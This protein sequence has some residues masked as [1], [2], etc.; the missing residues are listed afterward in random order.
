MMETANKM[1][2]DMGIGIDIPGVLRS[3]IKQVVYI[4]TFGIIVGIWGY[5]GLN[6]FAPKKYQTTASIVVI[7][8]QDISRNLLEYQMENAI[9][10]YDG[11]LGGDLFRQILWEGLSESE[12]SQSVF[13]TAVSGNM[14]TMKATA[15]NPET[16]YKLIKN[17]ISQY[18]SVAEYISSGYIVE[19]LSYPQISRVTEVPRNS[20]LSAL[21]GGGLAALCAAGSVGIIH[22]FS[23]KI[24][25]HMQAM[26][27]L[28]ADFIG[29][30]Q[31][32]SKVGF[33]KKNNLLVTKPIVSFSYTMDV[34]KIV[35]RLK[36]LMGEKNKQ[37]LLI[38]ST[39]ENEGKSTI[40]TN[41][42]LVLAQRKEKVLLLDFNLRK[43]N[44]AKILGYDIPAKKEITQ[45]LEGS[46]S[47]EIKWDFDPENN[48]YY[49]L[50]TKLDK[51]DKDLIIMN[52]LP[53]LLE[54]AKADMDYVIIDSAP[55]FLSQDTQV[56]GG[57]VDA[58]LLVVGQGEAKSD[59]INE[60][61]YECEGAG[62]EVLG[63]VLNRVKTKV[64][65]ARKRDIRYK[66]ND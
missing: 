43:P 25:N 22:I 63:I 61:I 66:R 19:T 33:R 35:N 40:A 3:I 20:V 37:I 64:V 36:R 9:N 52:N 38:S 26:R 28:D 53:L 65:T 32:E 24:D 27:R 60:C 55:F 14:I 31:Y 46:D 13:T 50:G 23:G 49:I 4:F 39:I 62:A 34:K 10:Q 29:E 48:I 7:A 44:L 21:L 17:A 47:K 11:I 5:I 12:K 1:A 6:Q 45:V 42:A 56:I 16:A 57:Y 58:V 41:I 18:R 51:G 15:G 54:R 2:P 59:M 8:N 30:I